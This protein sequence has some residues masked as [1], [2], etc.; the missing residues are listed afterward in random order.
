MIKVRVD[1]DVTPYR[2]V[3]GYRRCGKVRC[4]QFQVPLFL[5]CYNLKMKARCA[6]ELRVAVH[7]SKRRNISE[8]LNLH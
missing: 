8:D 2:L 1:W 7:Q 3:N 6:S 5:V 4:L